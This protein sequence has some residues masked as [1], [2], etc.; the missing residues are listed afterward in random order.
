MTGD[1]Q[2]IESQPMAARLAAV[3]QVHQ[4]GAIAFEEMVSEHVTYLHR[5]AFRLTH[6][7]AVAEDLVQ[8]TLERAY[9]AFDRYRPEGKA[10]AWLGCIM[11]NLWIYDH[12]RR[13][14]A[15]H[16]MPLD[17]TDNTMTDGG[18]ADALSTVDVEAAVL[19]ELGVATILRAID[20]LPSHLRQVVVLADVRDLPYGTVAQMLAVPIGTV[21]SRLSRG[22]RQLRAALHEQARGAGLLAR[23][24]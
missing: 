15:P 4:H 19:E 16:T 3:G 21:C 24:S 8:D 7:W 14:G 23:A 6:D 18:A 10:R 1:E 11:R 12:R 20:D 9:R 2:E 13:R 17:G 22:R 5:T